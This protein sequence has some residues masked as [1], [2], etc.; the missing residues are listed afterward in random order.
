MMKPNNKVHTYLNNIWL[1]SKNETSLMVFPIYIP[2]TINYFKLDR[3]K[4]VITYTFLQSCLHVQ[5]FFIE[6]VSLAEISRIRVKTTRYHTSVMNAP[7]PSV[8]S[9]LWFCRCWLPYPCTEIQRQ[10]LQSLLQW[11]SSG[12]RC[13]EK[14]L[15]KISTCIMYMIEKMQNKIEADI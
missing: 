14:I 7:H 4:I 3:L 2:V 5:I 6:I 8:L 9:V 12:K 11:W 1:Y 13:T 15:M 10:Q